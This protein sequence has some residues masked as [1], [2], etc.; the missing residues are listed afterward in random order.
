[1]PWLLDG[2]NLA[3]GQ[4]R[5]SVRRAALAVAHQERVR[6]LV[7]FD[8]APPE[9]VGETEKLGSVEVRYVG[10]ADTAI[11]AFLRSASQ[12]W[13]VATD[14]RALAVAARAAGAEVVPSARFWR[15]AAAATQAPGREAGSGSAVD[16][17][18]AY[19][20]DKNH[21]LPG[22]PRRIARRRPRTRR[23]RGL[24]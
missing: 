10:H 18:I 14:D 2:N 13:R 22:E 21:R 7:F 1:M 23:P 12:G 17:E 11:L 15:K 16:E 5:A 24:Q 3:R 9:G 20:A 19:F 6:I 4:D 8:G